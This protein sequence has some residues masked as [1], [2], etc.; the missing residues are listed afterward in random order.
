MNLRKCLR[1]PIPEIYEAAEMLAQAVDFHL[2]GEFS[3][4]ENL[5]RA[6][7]LGIIRDWTESIWGAKSPYTQYKEI[8][9]AEPY[10]NKNVRNDF[11]MPSNEIKMQIIKRDGYNCVFCGI[12]VIRKEIRN[13]LKKQYP[14]GLEWGKRNIEQHAAF[15]AMWLQY[16]H[17]LPHSRGGNND[18]DNLVITCA[19]C[20]FGRMQYTL[21]ELGIADPRLSQIAKS[22]WDGLERVIVKNKVK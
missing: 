1:E 11:R 7:N 22:N 15:Q 8:E 21:Q 3:Q 16:D 2:I 6:S 13:H 10:L 12:P 17:I 4:A 18:L 14:N 9:N 5:I 19:P 20:N